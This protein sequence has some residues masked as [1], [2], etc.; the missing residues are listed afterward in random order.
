LRWLRV[1]RFASTNNGIR[2]LWESRSRH[3]RRT[4]VLSLL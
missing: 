3:S 2:R 1:R 4:L